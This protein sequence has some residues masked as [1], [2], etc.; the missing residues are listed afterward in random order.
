MPVEP[1]LEFVES[2]EFEDPVESLE[3]IS[4]ILNRLLQQLCFRLAARA[5][6][7]N[8]LCLTL[9]LDVRQVNSDKRG[10]SYERRWKLPFATHNSKALFKLIHLDLETTTYNSIHRIV[11]VPAERKP[12]SP[13]LSSLTSNP[14]NAVSKC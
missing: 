10:E 14:L 12:G 11:L 13:P 8:E 7:T 1:P 9:S 4:F 2:F 6:A 3:G 5:L